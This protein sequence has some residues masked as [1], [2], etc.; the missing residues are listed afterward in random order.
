MTIMPGVRADGCWR[1]V[2]NH[3][4][5]LCSF[6]KGPGRPIAL[7]ATG[8][9]LMITMIDS[10]PWK[11][12]AANTTTRRVSL[13]TAIARKRHLGSVAQAGDEW[14]GNRCSLSLARDMGTPWVGTLRLKQHVGRDGGAGCRVRPLSI[15]LWARYLGGPAFRHPSCFF[16]TQGGCQPYPEPHDLKPQ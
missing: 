9:A 8:A 12:R 16:G 13:A 14:T 4:P 10:A 15:N 1:P 3:G 5:V 7:G 11:D 6:K 2:A